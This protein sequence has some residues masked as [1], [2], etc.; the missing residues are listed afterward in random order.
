MK[1]VKIY[2]KRGCPY[3]SRVIDFF[4]RNNLEFEGFDVGVDAKLYDEIKS[5]TGHQTVPQIFIVGEF[6]GGSDDFFHFL[7][8]E[9]QPDS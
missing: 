2:F 9:Y 8:H 4:E 5:I 3:C 1:N 6:I 7:E